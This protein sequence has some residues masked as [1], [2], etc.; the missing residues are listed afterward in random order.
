MC[1]EF[2]AEMIDNVWM[3]TGRITKTLHFLPDVH[4]F[5]NHG[6]KTPDETHKRVEPGRKEAWG[7][8][9]KRANAIG[10]EIGNLL[11]KKGVK[12]DSIC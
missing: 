6:G 11:L 9:K 5:H 1:E 4:L 12:G 2:R 3:E 8:G 10:A 7:I